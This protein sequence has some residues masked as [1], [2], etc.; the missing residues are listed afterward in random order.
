MREAT[1]EELASWGDTIIAR[2]GEQHFWQLPEFAAMKAP[3]WQAR[4]I[5]HST[6]TGEVPCLYLVRKLPFFGEYW[7]APMGPRVAD[8]NQFS[9]VVAD[10]RTNSAFAT[11]ME[12]TLPAYNAQAKA[13]LCSRIQGLAPVGDVQLA[14]HTVLIDIRPSEEELLASFKQ[15]TRR[16]LKKTLKDGATV[17]FV[18]DE[19]AFDVFWN[20]YATMAQRAGLDI[21]PRSYF[22]KTWR[23]WLEAGKGVLVLARPHPDA[24]IA[25]GAF[26]WR[27]GDRALYKDGGSLRIPEANGLQYLVQW[28]A[29][30]WAKEQGCTSYD[31]F[32][33]PP[34]WLIDDETHRL[35]GLVQFK[36][37]FGQPSDSM[38]A[39]VFVKSPRTYQL[40][41]RIGR[42]AFNAWARVRPQSFY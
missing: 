41:E 36:T 16:A 17:E 6:D 1:P 9:S 34:S 26:L 11:V 7:Y 2:P 29:M 25:A 15:R 12:P 39:V 5:I 35:H 14:A 33:M 42:R 28:E 19:S 20:L 18:T 21:P 23:I 8:E 10:L 40:W 24:D 30:R 32:G 22:E 13:E 3:A 4:Y 37:G 31:M 38:G 27:D